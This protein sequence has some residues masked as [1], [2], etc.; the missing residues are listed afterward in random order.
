MQN[1]DYE[2][3]VNAGSSYTICGDQVLRRIA[4]IRPTNKEN[5]ALVDG[6]NLVGLKS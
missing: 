6:V 5:L 4:A 3:S 1:I 2:I